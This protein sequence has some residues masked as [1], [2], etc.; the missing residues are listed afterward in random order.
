MGAST[1]CFTSPHSVLSPHEY[2]SFF[3]PYKS[4]G[5]SGLCGS[6]ISSLS[7]APSLVF[8]T[9]TACPPFPLPREHFFF[10]CHDGHFIT[11]PLLVIHFPLESFI[12]FHPLD[13]VGREPSVLPSSSTIDWR[14]PPRHGSPSSVPFLQIAQPDYI[15][16]L[17]YI[18]FFFS[19]T[20]EVML[21]PPLYVSFDPGQGLCGTRNAPACWFCTG[22]N[23]SPFVD[24]V[25][26]TFLS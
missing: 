9:R 14:S 17:G 18:F 16:L 22:Q 13:R 26:P 21:P 10:F 1:A 4:D 5:Q 3:L 19:Q 2:F 11:T 6:K 25:T 12:L 24:F 7:L 20:S 15:S 23:T 8:S